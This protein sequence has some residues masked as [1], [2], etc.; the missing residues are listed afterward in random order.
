[1]LFEYKGLLICYW[2]LFKLKN[3]LKVTEPNVSM[4]FQIGKS[5]T[6]PFWNFNLNGINSILFQK[7]HVF[8]EHR[9]RTPGEKIV[10]TASLKSTPH[11]Q[12]FRY[13][14]S[15]FCLPH[16]PK[17]SDLCL[18]WVSVV[19]VPEYSL[20]EDLQHIKQRWCHYMVQASVYTYFRIV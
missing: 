3:S 11:S 4:H 13:G 7:T 9:L 1:M 15:I 2:L 14:Q 6:L 18:H 8:P 20:F 17:S 5:Y 19:C 16:R 12:F 10:F